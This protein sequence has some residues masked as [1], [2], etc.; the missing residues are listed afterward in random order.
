MPRASATYTVTWRSSAGG[1]LATGFDGGSGAGPSEPGTINLVGP[2]G[3]VFP[4]CFASNCPA[5]Y[6]IDGRPGVAAGEVSAD[7]AAVSLV[8]PGNIPAGS[9][10]PDHTGRRQ[11]RQRRRP[12][13]V[14]LDLVR[15]RG[16]DAAISVAIGG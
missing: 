9:D 5:P 10:N 11:H 12:H 16:R 8:V 1:A 3:T 2:A 15:L 14:R 7:G 13:S 4:D 6:A